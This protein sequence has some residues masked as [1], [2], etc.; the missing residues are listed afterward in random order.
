MGGQYASRSTRRHRQGDERYS[1]QTDRSFPRGCRKREN[2]EQSIVDKS[3]YLS[4]VYS[5]ARRPESEYPVKL[6]KYLRQQFAP[7][8]GR[9][10]DM[11]CGR[12]DQLRAF[13]KAGFD[14]KG[15]DYS[16][17]AQDLCA[18]LEVRQVDL[19][20]EPLPYGSGSF[21]VVFS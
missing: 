1:Q 8:G 4:V 11:G 10:L 3:E 7:E 17:L 2:G 19:M 13:D 16:P 20:N 21:D 9:L 5:K 6:A 12:G 14:V 15:V 18:P